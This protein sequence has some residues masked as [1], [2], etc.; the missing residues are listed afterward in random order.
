MPSRPPPLPRRIVSVEAPEA[1]HPSSFV[2]LEECPLSVLGVRSARESEILVVHPTAYLGVVLHHVRQEVL[3]GR[4]GASTTAR[5]AA[6][7]IFK[8][9]LS[10]V[11]A[12]LAVEPATAGLVPLRT[13]VGRRKWR[14]RTQDLWAWADSVPS[15]GTAAPPRLVA[16]LGA[17]GLR[18]TP[19]V[20]SV[21]LGTERS[22]SSHVLRL[23]GRPDWSGGGG[24]GR[25]A[26]V[27][28][29]SGQVFDRDGNLL[30][31]H[32]TQLQLYAL[33]VEEARPDVRVSLYLEQGARIPVPWGAGPRER[34]RARLASMSA[35]VPRGAR[36]PSS[37]VA[38]PGTHC[39]RCRIRPCCPAY[40]ATAPPW[41]PDRVENPRPLPLDVWG[42]IKSAKTDP[43]GGLSI[44]LEDA[45]GRAV[46]VDG[47]A[48]RHGAGSLVPGEQ[49]WLFDLES[50]EDRSQHGVIV[51]PRNFHERPPGPRW[52]EARWCRVYSGESSAPDGDAAT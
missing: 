7:A 1:F 42:E 43:T 37:D 41:W 13:A 31:E 10:E 30:E 5:A 9:A 39:R 29:K 25:V 33:I 51:Q 4:W 21:D 27:D 28:F 20:D 22:L 15:V 3:E 6:D 50:S 48:P 49:V 11:E 36:L 26:I 23:R 17:R 45:A 38:D 52:S 32:V 34:I 19:A 47:L 40:L 18:A 24:R 14:T 46:R 16:V 2:R 44:R 8:A 12:A 35:R